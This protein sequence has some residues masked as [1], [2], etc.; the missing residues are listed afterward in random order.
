MKQNKN[1]PTKSINEEKVINEFL[2]KLV[3]KILSSKTDK[4]AN[5]VF[6]DDRL[7]AI[8]K[9]YYKDTQEFKKELKKLGVTSTND[10]K[11]AMNSN[12]RI[13]NYKSF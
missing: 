13:P 12:P 8:F 2:T 1:K 10:L 4:I 9:Q 7:T 6:T 11:K 3:T 5:S